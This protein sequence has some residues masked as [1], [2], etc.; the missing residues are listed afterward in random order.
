M[1][2]NVYHCGTILIRMKFLTVH[3]NKTTASIVYSAHGLKRHNLDLTNV[4]AFVSIA[5]LCVTSS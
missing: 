5:V 3:L 1:L 4:H 2:N